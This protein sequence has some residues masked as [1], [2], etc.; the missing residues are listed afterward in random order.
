MPKANGRKCFPSILSPRLRSRWKIVKTGRARLPTAAP[1]NAPKNP[2]TTKIIM[3]P[4]P[5]AIIPQ[6]APTNG[7]T[8][9]ILCH[10]LFSIS[11]TVLPMNLPEKYPTVAV[12]KFTTKATARIQNSSP[13]KILASIKNL[14]KIA[15]GGKVPSKSPKYAKAV[16]GSSGFLI[17]AASTF[18]CSE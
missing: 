14:V 2:P 16:C 17:T 7:S 11:L 12:I 6:R 18:S 15:A 4:A 5:P 10:D 9:I 1:T 3:P 13:R 8:K